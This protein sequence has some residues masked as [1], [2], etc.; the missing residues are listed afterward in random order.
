MNQK[1]CSRCGKA[2]DR[3]E[4]ALDMIQ[5]TKCY[6]RW[7]DEVARPAE[8]MIRAMIEQLRMGQKK[9]PA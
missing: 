9:L 8:P 2:L 4:R 6:S 1:I 5:C 7:V 3:N